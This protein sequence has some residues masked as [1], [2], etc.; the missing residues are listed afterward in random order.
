MSCLSRHDLSE[1][2]PPIETLDTSTYIPYNS[3]HNS[4]VKQVVCII[5]L[6]TCNQELEDNKTRAEALLFNHKRYNKSSIIH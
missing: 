5:G 1:I 4:L 2:K 3:F 6:L